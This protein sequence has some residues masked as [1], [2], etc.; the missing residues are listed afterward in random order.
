MIKYECVDL[1]YVHNP[2]EHIPFYHLIVVYHFRT[3][4]CTAFEFEDNYL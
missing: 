3:V 4:L 1:D 2:N